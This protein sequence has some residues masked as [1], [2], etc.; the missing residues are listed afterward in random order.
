MIKPI[1][2]LDIKPKIP[3]RLKPL[4]E[5][6]NNL[7]FSWNH[8]V[9]ELFRRMNPDLWEKLKKNPVEFLGR[10]SQPEL[11]SFLEDEGFLAHMERIKQDF[12]RYM[13][14]KSHYTFEKTGRPFTVAYFSAECGVADCLPIYSG[15]LGIL[16]G[17]H[18]KSAS[19]LNLPIV[20]VSLAY[21]KGYFRQQLTHEG[22]QAES[23]P[24]NQ[25]STMP[26]DLVRDGKGNIVKISLD[27]KG[28]EVKVRVWLVNIGRTK[29]YL[30]DTNLDENSKEARGITSELYGGDKEMRVRQEIILG[31]GGVKMLKAIGHDPEIYHMNEGHS[32]FAVFERIRELKEDKGLSFNEALEFVRT[33]NVFT[34]HTPIP[35]G[36]DM[37]HT[38]LLLPYFDNLARRLGI[39]VEVLFG[40]GKKDPRDK[41]EE[42]CMT[43]LALR[44]S[45][46]NNG[47]SRLHKHVSR[48]M[49]QGIWPKTME[50]D[51]PI[52]HVTNG[53]HIPSWISK[54][55][56]ENYARYLGPLWI[57]DPDNAMVW[58]RVD[59]IPDTELWRTHE[60]GRERLV[61]VSRGL[62]R[63]QLGKRGIP[64]RDIAIL[65]EVLNSETLTI[66]FARRFAPY[67]RAHLILKDLK[68]LEKILNN[69]EAPVQI[70]FAGKA[71][72]QD[73]MGKELIK[74]IIDISSKE[75]FR[76][77]MVFLEGFDIEVAQYMVQGVDVWLNTPR[78]P[79][80]ACGT[81]GMKAVA[82][83]ALHLSVLD[84]WWDEGYDPDIG[85]AI[86]TRVEY[87][88]HNYQDEIES[89]ALYDIL[90]KDI[91]PLFYNRGPDGIPR[92]WLTMMKA[93]L[94]KL[95]PMFNTH[96]MVTEY[97]TRFYETSVE[98]RLD[99]MEN[100]WQE[101]RNITKQQEKIMN[102]RSEL[103][104]KNIRMESISEIE[105]GNSYHVEADIFMGDLFPGDIT[106]EVYYGKLDPLNK[107]IESATTVMTS[108]G[109]AG[110]KIYQF[111]ADV[112]FEKVGHF[113]LNI[114]ITPTHPN[115]KRRNTMGLIIWGE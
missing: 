114:R 96:R 73:H 108:N 5:L 44:F 85:W 15:G 55:M 37:F 113:G 47:V 38:D 18:L 92:G 30:L 36:N 68:R 19:D 20:G 51:I 62:L 98:R 57:E 100:D 59:K 69:K 105:I 58:E 71:H 67:K 112:L 12:D 83:G 40:Y 41:D 110:E 88:D 6:A 4:N 45:N 72:P 101:L 70:I 22:W 11:T 86:G 24:V 32:A 48:K 33:T 95:C 104:I 74:Q 76:H 107:Y 43:V 2:T 82:N 79:L 39:N 91:V 78:R 102:S 65:D 46:C 56:A 14:E 50:A 27:L 29:L 13:A 10:L 60:R 53:V 115:P 17:D 63:K 54:G 64:N 75:N 61:S 7:W 28:E 87:D 80:E 25:F 81:S 106:V 21:Q 84:G 23:Y 8:E 42:F 66:G 90:E 34:T 94:L 1:T 31:I 99:L 49:W 9:E 26:M 16:A 111:Q 77:H 89:I 103:E 52:G 109:T 35:A 3:E 93:S 97:W